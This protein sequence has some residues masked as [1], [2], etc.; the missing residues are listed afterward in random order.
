MALVGRSSHQEG[1]NKMKHKYGP[2]TFCGGEVS[3]RLIEHEYRWQAELFLFE[4]VPAGVCQ[5]CGEV[6]FTIDTVKALEQAVLSKARPQ[7]T[8]QVPVFVYPELVPA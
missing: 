7:R 5:Q 2:C 6:Y 1:T 3:E 8:I 4:K